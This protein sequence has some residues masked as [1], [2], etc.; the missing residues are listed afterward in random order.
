[1]AYSF[2]FVSLPFLSCISFYSS[3]PSVLRPSPG[4]DKESLCP[5]LFGRVHEC[6]SIQLRITCVL[7]TRGGWEY[8]CGQ[9]G[10]KSG[11]NTWR[12]SGRYGGDRLLLSC[13]SNVIFFFKGSVRDSGVRHGFLV[14]SARTFSCKWTNVNDSYYQIFAVLLLT[15]SQSGHTDRFTTYIHIS[16]HI[17]FNVYFTARLGNTISLDV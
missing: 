5:L 9:G 4:S 3:F 11:M 7:N 13:F 8:C 2:L 12:C 17:H 10:K 6:F 14:R 1:M 15:C 16:H